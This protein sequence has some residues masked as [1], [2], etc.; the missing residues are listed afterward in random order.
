MIQTFF[1]R[2]ANLLSAFWFLETSI[3]ASIEV[4]KFNLDL[5]GEVRYNSKN[6]LV[7]NIK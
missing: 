5:R 7:R 2:L 6:E 3:E 4:S 1:K